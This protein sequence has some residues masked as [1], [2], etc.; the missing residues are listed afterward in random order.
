VAADLHLGYD[1]VRRRGGE[2]V[3]ARTVI[4]ELAALAA[5][6][7]AENTDR[8]VIAG[9]LFEDAR[10]ERDEL[11]AELIDWLDRERI[12]LVAVIPGNHDRGLGSAERL[13]ISKGGI[14]L[15]RWHI[16]HGDGDA[17][18]GAIVQGHEHPWFRWGDAAGPCYLVGDDHLV[19]P[20]YSRDAAGCNVRGV[21]RWSAYRCCVI[22]G[23]G[24]LDFGEVGRLDSASRSRRG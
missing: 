17:P 3:P 9:D 24:V 2:A 12:E 7:H 15:G 18:P 19:L 23:D 20:A 16:I 11:I 13:R 1:R 21:Q 22:A 6:L 8:L 5:G 14:D 10:V 4:E